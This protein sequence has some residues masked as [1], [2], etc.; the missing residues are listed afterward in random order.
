MKGI[1]PASIDAYNQH[2]APGEVLL[3]PIIGNASADCSNAKDKTSENTP[4][5]AHHLQLHYNSVTR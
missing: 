1:R 5:P 2:L 3:L 4:R